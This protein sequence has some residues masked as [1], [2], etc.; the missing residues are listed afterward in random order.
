MWCRFGTWSVH[1][2]VFTSVP[3][4]NPRAWAGGSIRREGGGV[5]FFFRVLGAFFDS[6]FHSEHFEYAQDGGREV[7]HQAPEL[8]RG[9]VQKGLAKDEQR[10]QRQGTRLFVQSGALVWGRQGQKAQDM[11]KGAGMGARGEG[12]WKTEDKRRGMGM[13]RGRRQQLRTEVNTSH[14]GR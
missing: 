9:I 11:E 12:K 5:S 4:P 14:G 2:G 8:A 6:L 7:R 13:G 3:D 1:E 10:P